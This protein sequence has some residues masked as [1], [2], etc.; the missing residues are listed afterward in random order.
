MSEAVRFGTGHCCVCTGVCHHINGPWYCTNHQP[1]INQYTDTP[2][3]VTPI[4]WPPTPT[5]RTDDLRTVE[6]RVAECLICGHVKPL[7][8]WKGER[9]DIGVC[10]ECR[11]L[12]A[13][14]RGPCS[15]ACSCPRAVNP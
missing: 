5:W 14:L 3:V 7:A 13:T 6:A 2:Y 9:P 1:T 10:R 11:D 4:P 8:V 15:E 12:A